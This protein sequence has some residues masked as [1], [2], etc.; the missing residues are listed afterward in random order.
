MRRG[1]TRNRIPVMVTVHLTLTLWMSCGHLQ[2]IRYSRL[3][4]IR[5]VGRDLLDL[6][7][8]HVFGRFEIE[9]RLHVH[10][11]RSASLE[12]FAEPQ[13]GVRRDWLFFARNALD[14]GARYVQS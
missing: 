11:E 2:D 10:P 4:L 3:H 8:E 14:P 1:S 7:C 9:A 12:E 6:W 13:R 5:L